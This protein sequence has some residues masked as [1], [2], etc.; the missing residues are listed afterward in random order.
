MGGWVEGECGWGS[1]TSVRTNDTALTVSWAS[2]RTVD[3][4]ALSIPA[5]T[6]VCSS[7]PSFA[8]GEYSECS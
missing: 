3:A 5:T 8:Q 4:A 1:G 2:V 7:D 6:R